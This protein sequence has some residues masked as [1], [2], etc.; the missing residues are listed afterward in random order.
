MTLNFITSRR[1][2]RIW[3]VFYVCCLAVLVFRTFRDGI[4]TYGFCDMFINYSGGFV[5]RGLLGS[6]FLKGM[7]CGISPVAAAMTLCVVS[8][9]AVAAYMLWQFRRRGYS[10]ELLAVCFLLGGVG[11]YGFPFLRR[12]FFIL[13]M[14]LL[15]MILR[16]RLPLAAWLVAGNI[17][18]VFTILCYEPFAFFG[19]P[20]F[21]LATR[22]R[23]GG[24]LRPALCWL[25]SAASF[26]VCCKY[27]GDAAS[28]AAMCASTRSFL[29]TPGIMDFI[30]KKSFDV[31]KFH[32]KM[33][34][35]KADHCVPNVLVSCVSI[36]SVLY[37]CVN[38]VPLYAR[39]KAGIVAR[40][41]V[42]LLLLLCALFFQL[43]MFVCLSTDYSR[44]LIY[45]A[46]S[47]FIMHFT[48]SD[49]ELDRLFPAPLY[50]MADRWLGAA[51]R[52]LPPSRGKVVF[53]MMFIGVAA[54][55][56]K[57]GFDFLASS[58]VGTA[59]NAVVTLLKWIY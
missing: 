20:F 33:N 48:L 52:L 19:L 32:V 37:Y 36:F 27:S 50:S 21:I 2:L 4:V 30:P 51:D 43:P 31:M 42:M 55:T 49:E 5:R 35:F 17:V 11:V 25:P 59:V 13:A 24:W 57:P 23:V 8:F 56:S 58:E 29:E 45:T 26:L 34:F 54:W 39:Q 14:F 47:A 10:V 1:F 9:I 41:N 38:A 12:D 7:N 40:R 28:Y 16:Q 6:L 22:L 46:V 53:I 18:S 44:L 3:T 15:V